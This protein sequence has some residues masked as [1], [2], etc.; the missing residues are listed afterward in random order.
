MVV[1]GAVV[2]TEIVAMT[3]VFGPFPVADPVQAASDGK[4]PHANVIAVLRLLELMRLTVVVPEPPGLAIV[5]LAGL[6]TPTKPGETAK[7]D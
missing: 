6:E 4:P 5:T 1:C 7:L 3:G 2:V